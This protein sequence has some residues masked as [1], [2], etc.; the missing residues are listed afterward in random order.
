VR[1]VRTELGLEQRPPDPFEGLSPRPAGEPVLDADALQP[2]AVTDPRRHGEGHRQPDLG[3]WAEEGEAEIVER[4]VEGHEPAVGEEPGP[5]P[6]PAHF[7][8]QSDLVQQG[9]E[10][11]VVGQDHVVV[12]VPDDAVDLPDRRQPAH[13]GR[14]FAHRHGVAGLT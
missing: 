6:D 2:A 4:A 10:L 12:L 3:E 13:G 5:T 9:Q 11:A 1:V 7:A 14:R 8:R